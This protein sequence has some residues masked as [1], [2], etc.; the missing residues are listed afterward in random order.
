VTDLD[1]LL[2][3]WLAAE[4][5]C[6]ADTTEGLLTD[7]FIGIGPVG[8]QLPKSAWLQRLTSGDLRY[9][10]LEL[11][12]LTTRTYASCAVTTARCDASGTA[13]GHPLPEATRVTL[14]AIQNDGGW[15]LA[16]VQHSFIAGTPGAPGPPGS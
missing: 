13:Q 1:E 4:R 8:F 3:S 9:D 16:N 5:L 7:D 6:D 14:V 12:E 10:R 2:D 11:S 15:R